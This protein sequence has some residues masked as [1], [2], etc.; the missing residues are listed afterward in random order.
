MIKE[1]ANV[2]SNVA[3]FYNVNQI[4]DMIKIIMFNDNVNQ[5]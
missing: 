4:Y 3:V 1:Y 5:I 2:F